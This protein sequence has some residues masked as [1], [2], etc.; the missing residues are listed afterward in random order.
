MPTNIHHTIAVV[1]AGENE[2]EK[3]RGR[4]LTSSRNALLSYSPL[5]RRGRDAERGKEEQKKKEE[6][7]RKPFVVGT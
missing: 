5:I 7:E 3:E 2:G 6:E 4:A 1:F